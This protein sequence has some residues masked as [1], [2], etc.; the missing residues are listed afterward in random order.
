MK[1]LKDLEVGSVIDLKDHEHTIVRS[2]V[3]FNDLGTV[4]KKENGYNHEHIFVKL[5]K[6]Y[7][8][9]NEW[10]N[11]LIFDKESEE[12]QQGIKAKFNTITTKEK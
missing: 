10:E 8:F 1:M 6:Q 5:N 7:D 12:I 4:I 3:I 2:H 11:C 9:L